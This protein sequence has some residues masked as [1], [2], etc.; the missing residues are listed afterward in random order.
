VHDNADYQIFQNLFSRFP[1]CR[2]CIDHMAG[3]MGFRDAV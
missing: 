3:V 2:P 1:R